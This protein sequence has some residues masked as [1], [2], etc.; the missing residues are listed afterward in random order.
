MNF[1]LN[2]Y[3]KDIA[4]KSKHTQLV[5]FKMDPDELFTFSDGVPFTMNIKNTGEARAEIEADTLDEAKEIVKSYINVK[6]WL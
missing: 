3:L 4:E 6:E 2:N 1:D 5:K